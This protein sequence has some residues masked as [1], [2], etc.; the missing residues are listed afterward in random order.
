MSV[1]HVTI[2]DGVSVATVVV[3]MMMR[4][5]RHSAVRRGASKLPGD[6]G[7]VDVNVAKRMMMRKRRIVSMVIEGIAVAVVVVMM[8][9][10]RG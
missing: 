7:D 6:G 5:V 4:G 8:S 2:G 1:H 10:S 9:G 3:V